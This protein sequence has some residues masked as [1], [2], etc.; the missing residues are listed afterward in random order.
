[1]DVAGCHGGSRNKC[2]H[3]EIPGK[4]GKDEGS[5]KGREAGDSLHGGIIGGPRDENFGKRDAGVKTQG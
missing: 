5:G 4:G 2:G 3:N 1:M